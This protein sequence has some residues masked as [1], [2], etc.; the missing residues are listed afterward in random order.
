MDPK[1]QLD[2]NQTSTSSKGNCFSCPE[3]KGSE[4][5]KNAQ[6]QNHSCIKKCTVLMYHLCLPEFEKLVH[7]NISI[8]IFLPLTC[9]FS[10]MKYCLQSVT[11]HLDEALQFSFSCYCHDVHILKEG[12]EFFISI[13]ICTFLRGKHE[14]ENNGNVPVY[15]CWVLKSDCY[16]SCK[17]P[18]LLQHEQ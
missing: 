15:L 4:F 8:I 6:L 2:L 13:D 1:P 17:A 3:H 14:V 9:L 5:D 16:K 12:K 11:S 10:E 18:V 7:I